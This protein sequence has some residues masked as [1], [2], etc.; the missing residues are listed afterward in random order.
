MFKPFIF[1]YSLKVSSS[2]T[3]FR[4]GSIGKF[5]GMVVIFTFFLKI[6]SDRRRILKDAG[7]KYRCVPIEYESN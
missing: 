1:S 6:T 4:R 7:V 5:I 2:V 3:G